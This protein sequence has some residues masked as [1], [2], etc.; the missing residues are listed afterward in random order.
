MHVPR[1]PLHFGEVLSDPF[2]EIVVHP[3]DTGTRAVQAFALRRAVTE[4]HHFTKE[5]FGSAPR[6]FE[7]KDDGAL[8]LL[9]ERNFSGSKDLYDLVADLV[10]GVAGGKPA[11]F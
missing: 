10:Q 8:L 4:I 9:R 6:L 1:R 11:G 3:L 7:D 2:A 5:L